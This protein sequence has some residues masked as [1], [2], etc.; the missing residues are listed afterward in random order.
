MKV[1]KSPRERRVEARQTV[2]CE[3]CL[4]ELALDDG[5]ERCLGGVV[6]RRLAASL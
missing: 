4:S 6:P 3:R 1:F 5:G 2:T